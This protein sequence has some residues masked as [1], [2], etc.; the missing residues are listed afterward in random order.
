MLYHLYE[1]L[2]CVVQDLK[3]SVFYHSYLVSI[4]PLIAKNFLPPVICLGIIAVV[5]HSRTICGCHL[6]HFFFFT[7]CPFEYTTLW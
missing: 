5:G 2:L 6:I 1:I 4:I 3:F 7:L